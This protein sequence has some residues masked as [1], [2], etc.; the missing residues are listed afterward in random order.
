MKWMIWD[1]S[2]IHLSNILRSVEAWFAF[3]SA[4]GENDLLFG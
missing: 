2:D 4:G 1:P 3:T